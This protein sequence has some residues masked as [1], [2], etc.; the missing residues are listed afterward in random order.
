MATI[1]L[2]D[3]VYNANA[4]LTERLANKD[5]DEYI[6]DIIHEVADSHTPVF[7]AQLLGIA[8]HSMRLACTEPEI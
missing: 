1:R 2:S 4:D 6:G 5:D 3:L 7:Y 8:S